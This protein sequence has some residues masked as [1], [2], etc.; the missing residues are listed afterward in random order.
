M[1]GSGGEE[2]AAEEGDEED[3]LGDVSFVSPV[4]DNVL[5]EI[6][7]NARYYDQFCIDEDCFRIGKRERERML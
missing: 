7:S 2:K 3:D 4:L 1:A 5:L 6:S